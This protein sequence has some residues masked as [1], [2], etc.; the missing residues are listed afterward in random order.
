L[1]ILLLSSPGFA[2]PRNV[3]VGC[4]EIENFFE[5]DASGIVSGYGADYLDA[6][7]KETGWTYE[8]V[9]GTWSEC[10][11]SLKEGSVDLLLPAE[12]SKE[13]SADFIFSCAETNFD[14]VTLLTKSENNDLFYDDWA[15]YPKLRIGF[16]QDNFLNSVFESYATQK[17]FDYTAVTF[18]SNP[19]MREALEEGKI[20]AIVNGNFNL[21]SGQKILGLVST[22]PAFFIVRKGEQGL[23]SELDDAIDAINIS[24]PYFTATLIEKYSISS[25]MVKGY[26]KEEHEFAASSPPIR[27]AGENDDYPF[28]WFDEKEKKS[29]GITP[30]IFD[31]LAEN[32]GL[33]F[34]FSQTKEHK[35]SWEALHNGEA[36]VAAGVYADQWMAQKRDA[37]FSN[38]YMIEHYSAIGRKDKSFPDAEGLMVAVKATFLGMKRFI[39]KVHPGWKIVDCPSTEGCLEAV[40]KGN[41]DIALIPSL[42]L[43]TEPVLASHQNL[44]ISPSIHVDLP[45]SM[46]VRNS[47][48]S[49]LLLSTLNKAIQLVGSDKINQCIVKN[50]KI[51]DSMYSFATIVRTNTKNAVIFVV[52]ILGLLFCFIF[53]VYHIHMQKMQTKMLRDQNAFLAKENMAKTDFLATMSHDVRTPLNIILGM[54]GLAEKENDIS[55]IRSYLADIKDSSKYLLVLSNDV[56]DMA[57]IDKNQ[58]QL[59]PEP[60][61]LPD[62]VGQLL[63]LVS[64]LCDQKHIKLAG[65][66]SGCPMRSTQY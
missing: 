1:L 32:S 7:A 59:K 64:P 30:A 17:G 19:E 24:Q 56:L 12:Y 50:T 23:I 34:A 42:R 29:Q 5:T 55:A 61:T 4:V 66:Y 47:P 18:P 2:T 40:E 6:I 27:I 38:P 16:L 41:A 58:M 14:Y 48:D 36:D 3:R 9:H 52:T 10:L 22:L 37:L 43:Q 60:A 28:I 26:T 65:N 25:M 33:S 62:F 35:Q 20:D 13:R 54:E 21:E 44:T 53:T 45:I 49:T 39:G 46:A 15:N 11:A 31:L 57:K 63:S 8:Y 51:R